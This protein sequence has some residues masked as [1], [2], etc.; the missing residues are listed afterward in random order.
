[1]GRCPPAPPEEGGTERNKVPE[2]QG[3]GFAGGE[4]VELETTMSRKQDDGPVEDAE[5]DLLGEM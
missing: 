3:G 1:M 4:R 5:Y 2:A